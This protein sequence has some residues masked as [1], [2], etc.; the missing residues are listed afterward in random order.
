[1]S[2]VLKQSPEVLESG[3]ITFYLVYNV[4]DVLMMSPQNNNDE[5]YEIRG[6]I[7]LWPLFLEVN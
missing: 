7:H 6:K 2:R 4:S 1:M 3:Q 5:R